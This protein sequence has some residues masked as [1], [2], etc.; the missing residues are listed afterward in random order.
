M[1]Q[2]IIKIKTF[3]CPTG[4][5]NID[6][7]CRF[8]RSIDNLPA[9]MMCPRCK[10]ELV[11]AVQENDFV[12]VTIMGEYEVEDLIM[13]DGK[14]VSSL[15]ADAQDLSKEKGVRRRLNETEFQHAMEEGRMPDFSKNKAVPFSKP[16]RRGLTPGE[17]QDFIDRIRADTAKFR[18]IEAVVPSAPQG[19][20]I[21]A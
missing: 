19:K 5:G 11:P 7:S 8:H 3:I 4:V 6:A 2:T 1:P 14:C 17:K 20:E 15:F 16:I 9:D 21:D 13:Y 10:V 18:A 12:T